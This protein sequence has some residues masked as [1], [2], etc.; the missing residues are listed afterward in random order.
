[1]TVEYLSATTLARQIRTGQ[2]SPV[3]ILDA[4]FEQIE[5]HD[6]EINA[7]VHL[8]REDAYEAA[9][10]A[11]RAIRAGQDLGPL[12]GVP[13]AIKDLDTPVEGAPMTCG[14]V[15]LAD[16]IAD[17]DCL[18]VERLKDAGAIVIGLTN[19]PEFGHKG[20]TDNPLHGTTVTPFDT[21]RSAGGSS[22]GSAA[23]LAAGMTPLAVGSD[24]G[25]SIRIPASACRVVGLMPS[26]GLVSFD[27]RPD[28]LEPHSPFRR[29]AR[30]P[31]RSR[32]SPSC[33]M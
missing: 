12:H 2:R 18:L 16:S 10:D 25:G 5:V 14:S 7:F 13:V 20:T 30:W 6:E 27:A 33:W 19:V 1:M 31:A 8:C 28:A 26:F 32:T 17:E 24:A 23:A 9:R 4:L 11:E 29:L 22:G 21:D 15:P 3:A